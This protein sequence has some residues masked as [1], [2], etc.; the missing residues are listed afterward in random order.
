[1]FGGG[2]VSVCFLNLN[3]A[4]DISCILEWVLSFGGGGGDCEV[5]RNILDELGVVSS[6]SMIF[7]AYFSHLFSF[8]VG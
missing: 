2:G 1:M 8:I 3:S 6:F 7:L 4:L 5:W